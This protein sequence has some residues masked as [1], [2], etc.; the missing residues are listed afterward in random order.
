VHWGIFLLTDEPLDQPPRDLAAAKLALGVNDADFGVLAIG[1]SKQFAKRKV[2][3]SL[4]A[5]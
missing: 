4:T 1:E 5:Q 2:T 3:S